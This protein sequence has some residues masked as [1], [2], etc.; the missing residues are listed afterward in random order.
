MFLVHN[1]TLVLLYRYYESRILTTN[2]V[3]KKGG[4]R[5]TQVHAILADIHIRVC[6]I[7]ID[8]LFANSYY[9]YFNKNIFNLPYNKKKNFNQKKTMHMC[10]LIFFFDVILLCLNSFF[11]PLTYLKW[12]SFET[13]WINIFIK[14]ILIETI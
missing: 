13:S 4:V 7:G 8:R 11:V 12:N 2:V 6:F 1:C 3:M 10:G 14:W 9:F 5:R